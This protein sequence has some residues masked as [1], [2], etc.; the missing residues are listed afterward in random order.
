MT[1]AR[2]DPKPKKHPHLWQA[3][4]WWEEL[5]K[6]RIRHILR[7][8]SIEAGKS[9]MDAQFERDM[10]E[11][12]GVE[13]LVCHAKKE[14]INFGET[15][16][17]VWDWLISIKG[18][19]EYSA[20]K[21]L[22]RIDDIGKFDTISKL[23]RFSGLAVIDG[24]AEKKDSQHYNRRL[25]AQM[26]GEQ[27]IADQFVRHHTSP[28]RDEYGSYK[29]RQRRK[30]PDVMCRQCGCKWDDCES[31]KSHKRMYNNGHLDIRAKR[32]IAKLF[33]SHLWLK[34]RELDG[35]PVSAPYVEAIMGHTNII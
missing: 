33:L 14:M 4:L 17:P 19:G 9:N 21:L 18:I 31:K 16:G 2:P 10:T 3:Y 12:V 22:A 6:M 32:K 30:Y 8:S 28:Y 25:K 24:K 20:A 11:H 5:E 29:A 15:V 13:A 1:D 27:G 7:I 23:W 35:L 34:W 26:V